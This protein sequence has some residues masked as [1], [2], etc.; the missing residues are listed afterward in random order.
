MV[1]AG[2]LG[3]KGHVQVVV[4]RKT[5]SYGSSSDAEQDSIPLCTIR[6]YPNCIEHTI[7]WA[8]AEFKSIFQD[9]ERVVNDTED[10]N[11]NVTRGV[12]YALHL[13]NEYFNVNISKQLSMHPPD[14]LTEEGIPFWL[15]PKKLPHPIKFSMDDE[16]HMLFVATLVK[17]FLRESVASSNNIT[18][19]EIMEKIF[20]LKD[21]TKETN[22]SYTNMVEFEKDNYHSDLIYALSN[23]RARNYDIKEQTKH[24]ITGVAGK[25]I[26]AIA[27]TT[28]MVSGLAIL[29]I[30]KTLVGS[31]ENK[32]SFL[33]LAHPM[34]CSADPI[35][36]GTNEYTVATGVSE[37][38]TKTRTFTMWDYKD[39]DD[40]P[41]SDIISELSAYYND[42]ANM[43]SVGSRILYW[44]IS[45]KYKGNL[46]KK[47][48]EIV[49]VVE[50]Q[51]YI[52]LTVF[53]EDEQDREV[54][55]VLLE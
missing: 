4:P 25:I 40:K 21:F 18:D 53:T 54:I 43:L 14:H 31:A 55:R 50:G 46:E 19:E 15:P 26:P 34:I 47:P 12:K 9:E 6:S 3:T 30:M 49:D 10:T 51:K 28:A 23:I 41:L 13:F 22:I 35:E 39:V 45:N 27:T 24:Y 33:D 42:T 32:N 17:I 1:D 38:S 2:T 7:E 20:T 8:L 16:L 48:S 5:E 44:D 52:Y 36:C 11:N 37:D 29:E